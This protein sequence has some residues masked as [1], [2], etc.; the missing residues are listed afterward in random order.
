V[1]PCCAGLLDPA[2]RV[3]PLDDGAR[4]ELR[5]TLDRYAGLGL[6]VLPAARRALTPGQP[7]PADRQAAESGLTLPGRRR[8]RC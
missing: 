2:G 8:P 1:L 3:R 4:T 5:R 7:V 6:R